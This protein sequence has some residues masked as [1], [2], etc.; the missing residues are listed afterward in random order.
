M[1]EHTKIQW[2]DH[3]FNGWLGCQKVHEGCKNC[4]AEALMDLRYGRVRWGG[5]SAGGTRPEAFGLNGPACEICGSLN[6]VVSVQQRARYHTD[7]FEAQVR[8]WCLT[9]RKRNT[10][11]YRRV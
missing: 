9:C 10:G 11:T 3:T 1:A 7:R 6:G 4:Y 8:H 5:V 2:A